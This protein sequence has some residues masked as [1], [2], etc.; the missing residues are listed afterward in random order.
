MVG[1]MSGTRKNSAILDG[2]MKKE[3]AFGEDCKEKLDDH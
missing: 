2:P 1:G 3:V